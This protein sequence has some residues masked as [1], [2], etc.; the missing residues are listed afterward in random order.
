MWILDCLREHNES[1]V[2][3]GK[4]ELVNIIYP[5]PPFIHLLHLPEP[6][7]FAFKMEAAHS[8]EMS[9]QTHDPPLCKNPED[10]NFYDHNITE[11]LQLTFIIPRWVLKF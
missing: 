10:C 6:N 2:S 5:F 9:E 8:I 11:G 7:S 1:L 3:V 4:M